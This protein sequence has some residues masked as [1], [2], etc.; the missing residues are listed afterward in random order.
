MKTLK[1]QYT[2]P[3]ANIVKVSVEGMLAASLP[4]SVKDEVSNSEQL[5][6]TSAWNSRLWT[7][8]DNETE[9]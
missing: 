8:D 2:T 7:A 5:S 6:N 4:N 3:Q 9:Y 1:K